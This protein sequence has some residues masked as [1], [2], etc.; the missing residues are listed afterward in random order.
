VE[1]SVAGQACHAY[2]VM[3]IV[4]DMRHGM[5]LTQEGYMKKRSFQGRKVDKM[6]IRLHAADCAGLSGFHVNK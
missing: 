4:E 5:R 1:V 2:S 6:D 3:H